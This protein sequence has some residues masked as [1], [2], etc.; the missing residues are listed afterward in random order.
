M[1][2]KPFGTAFF[3][4]VML[5]V[6]SI[7]ITTEP[8]E[9]IGRTCAPIGWVG[10]FSASVMHLASADLVTDTEDFFQ[11]R[12]NNCEYVVWRQFYED[13]YMEREQ[14]I[15]ALKEEIARREKALKEGRK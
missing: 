14:R 4:L 1:M 10:K 15:L 13:D 2:M 9:R 11:N 6:G 5:W 8:R 3:L 12:S 7:L